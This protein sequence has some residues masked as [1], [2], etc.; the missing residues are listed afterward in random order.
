MTVAEKTIEETR[1]A[2]KQGIAGPAVDP[3]RMPLEEF[4]KRAGKETLYDWLHS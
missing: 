2:E 4:L 3:K 1:D